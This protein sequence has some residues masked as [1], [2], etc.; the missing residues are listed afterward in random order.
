MKV[1]QIGLIS[2]KLIDLDKNYPVQDMLLQTGQLTQFSSGIYAYGHIPYLLKNNINNIIRSTLTKYGC[3]EI[4]LPLLQPEKIWQDSGRLERYVSEDVMFRCL[5]DKGNFCLAP[6][7][8]EAVVIYAKS[9]LTSYKHLPV[10]FFQIGE[11][12]RNE[13]RTRGY[14][15]RG[16]SFEMM[17]A[18]SFGKDLT[19]LELEYENIKMAYLEI[20]K[21]LQLNVQPVGAD[22]GA[23]GGNKSE[24]F[25]LISDMGEYNILFDPTTGMA[26]NEELLERADYKE[27]LK[28]IYGID[29]IQLLET[30]K[31]VELGHIF[32]LGKKYSESMAATY[33]DQTGKMQNYFMGCYGIGVTRTLAM[34]YENSI[35]RK[36]G[37]FDGISLPVNISP[38][39]LY[40]ISKTDNEEKNRKA[41]DAYNILQ[42][43]NVPV[44]F[45]DRENISIGVK[46]KDSKIVGTP[47]VVVFGKTLDDG[48]V[49]IENNKTGVK[50]N[51]TIEELINFFDTLNINK[52]IVINDDKDYEGDKIYTKVRKIK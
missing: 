44:L 4:S 22:S 8:E 51:I 28:N 29:N 46:I 48:Y 31:A 1:S 3:S 36:N 5:T 10:T 25:M 19:D 11:K 37:K 17:D 47:Y 12:F 34:I 18:Y 26:F 23:I 7:A 2:R 33:T 40:I 24:E 50:T 32:Q 35:I 42:S 9:K 27:Y 15:L 16:K 20:F 13:I 30:K 39:L 41:I 21:K 49:E 43:R 14:L 52:N 6:T 38:Y 45:D